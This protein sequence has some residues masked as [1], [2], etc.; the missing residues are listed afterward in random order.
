MLSTLLGRL[1]DL[2]FRRVRLQHQV[3][4]SLCTYRHPIAFYLGDPPP[5]GP[6][7]VDVSTELWVPEHRTTVRNIAA[8]AAGQPLQTNISFRFV[9]M[10]LEPGAKPEKQELALGPP[11]GESLR[12]KPGDRLKL[13]L[14]LTRGRPRTLK[15]PITAESD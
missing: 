15:V 11:E 1:L 14:V 10:T 5:R 12:A 9:P 13:T 2:A 4:A 3:T 6:L 7:H 8:E